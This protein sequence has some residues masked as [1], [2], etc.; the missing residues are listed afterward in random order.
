MAIE[1][2][3]EKEKPVPTSAALKLKSEITSTVQGV[4]EYWGVFCCFGYR[5]FEAVSLGN[6]QSKR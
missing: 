1:S 5:I 2:L 6:N 4:T 3:E